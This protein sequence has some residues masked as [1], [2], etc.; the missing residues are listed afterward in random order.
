MSAQRS[1]HDAAFERPS[2][3]EWAEAL[4][5][6][7]MTEDARM[8]V[9]LVASLEAQGQA[10]M[11]D[12]KSEHPQDSGPI[13]MPS[14]KTPWAL[15][16][17]A[18]VLMVGAG[19]GLAVLT[20]H[21]DGKNSRISELETQLA[22]AKQQAEQNQTFLADLRQQLNARTG[23]LSEAQTALATADEERL[24]L[25]ERLALVTSDL[26][27]AELR[28]ARYEEPVD[29]ATL[30]TNRQKLL[31]VPGTMRLAWSPFD[32]PDNPAEQRDVTGDV[33]WNEELE[34]GYL[35]FVGLDVNDPDVEQYQVWVI[36]DRGMEQKVS[37]GVF[38]ATAEGEIIVPIDPALDIGRVALF[39]ITV[40][41]PGGIVVP[42]LRRRVV[43]APRGEG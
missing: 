28:I 20:V 32:L 34:Q 23:E 31:D 35:R 38:N 12:R 37:G 18:A 40:E 10:A 16:G 22:S 27:S 25:A 3:D 29:P 41:E 42:D 13:Q 26:E 2:E 17:I 39:A 5:L 43:V 15:L 19:I 6:A 36:D 21:L 24:E 33:V 7:S 1:Q 14:R 4:L 8:P 30:A 9:A 11:N